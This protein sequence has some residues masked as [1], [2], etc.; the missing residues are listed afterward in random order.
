M[1]TGGAHTKGGAVLVPKVAQSPSRGVVAG[2]AEEARPGPFGCTVVGELGDWQVPRVAVV[3][4][5]PLA[6]GWLLWM[7][8]RSV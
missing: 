3:R 4:L 2:G 1:Q 5:P 7:V 8:L 6:Q